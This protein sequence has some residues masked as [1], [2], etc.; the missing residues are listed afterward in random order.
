MES[1]NNRRY[2]PPHKRLIGDSPAPSVESKFE[3][4]LQNRGSTTNAIKSLTD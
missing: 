2:V 1:Q 4:F 3:K